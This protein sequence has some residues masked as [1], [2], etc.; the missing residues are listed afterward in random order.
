MKHDSID[1]RRADTKSLASDL[2][3]IGEKIKLIGS[4]LTVLSICNPEW[5]LSEEDVLRADEYFTTIRSKLRA[6]DSLVEGELKSLK[7]VTR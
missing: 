3:E 2:N 7:R 4:E 1:I 5:A 6:L